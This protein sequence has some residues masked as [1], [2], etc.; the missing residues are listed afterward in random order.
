MARCSDRTQHFAV[1]ESCAL[2]LPSPSRYIGKLKNGG[3]VFDQTKGNATFSF[4]LGVGEVIKGEC[5]LIWVAFW[6]RCN[7][8]CLGAPAACERASASAWAWARSS[9][10][11]ALKKWKVAIKRQRNCA[12]EGAWVLHWTSV[13]PTFASHCGCRSRS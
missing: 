2:P 8:P 10:A 13:H 7:A 1:R 3:K 11:S 5:L 12:V 4:R 6:Q 9:R